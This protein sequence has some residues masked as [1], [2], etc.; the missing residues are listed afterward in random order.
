MSP[1]SSTI[2]FIAAASSAGRSAGPAAR[3]DSHWSRAASCDWPGGRCSW[4]QVYKGRRPRQSASV[5]L[6]NQTCHNAF[7]N[8]A[9]KSG[10]QKRKE[11]R[12]LVLPREDAKA[13][14]KYRRRGYNERTSRRLQW[15]TADENGDKKARAAQRATQGRHLHGYQGCRQVQQERLRQMFENGDKMRTATS[16]LVLRRELLKDA[17]RAGHR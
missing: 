7:R 9:K 13:V 11:S 3:R 12:R 1:L 10:K 15:R 8:V 4:H 16:R 14:D 2:T 5:I 6:W 17:K